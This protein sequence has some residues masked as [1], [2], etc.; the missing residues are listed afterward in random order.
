MATENTKAYKVQKSKFS[1]GKANC[2]KAMT[3]LESSFDDFCK[4]KGSDIPIMRRVRFAAELM[5]AV[6]FSKSKIKELAKIVNTFIN[7]ITDLEENNFTDPDKEAVLKKVHSEQ[8]E[9]EEKHH[10]FLSKND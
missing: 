1:V 4:N 9:Y 6:E 10:E 7:V 5:E 8:E 3:K 2:T